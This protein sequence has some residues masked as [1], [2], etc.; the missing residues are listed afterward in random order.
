MC[1][2]SLILPLPKHRTQEAQVAQHSGRV[3]G[4]KPHN[5]GAHI[6]KLTHVLTRCHWCSRCVCMFGNSIVQC[7]ERTT[8]LFTHTF[9]ASEHAHM[10]VD[11]M[12]VFTASR[13][14]FD[15]ALK[16][17]LHS[18]KITMPNLI[19][20]NALV[21]ILIHTYGEAMWKILINIPLI[22]GI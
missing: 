13:Y 4:A 17:T 18:P 11:E 20:Q 1:P 14:V 8:S 9:L 16:L 10:F 7:I 21:P 15:Y 22:F 5:F 3:T 12:T 2:Q 6:S 19:Q